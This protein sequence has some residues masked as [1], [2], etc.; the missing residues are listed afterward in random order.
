MTT[1]T[2]PQALTLAANAAEGLLDAASTLIADKNV[3]GAQQKL[4]NAET[5]LKAGYGLVKARRIDA[6]WEAPQ[7]SNPCLEDRGLRLI[8]CSAIPNVSV[9]GRQGKKMQAPYLYFDAIGV[10]GEELSTGVFEGFVT[11]EYLDPKHPLVGRLSVGFSGALSGSTSVE[12]MSNL[13]PGQQADL[14]DG[15]VLALGESSYVIAGSYT[16]TGV[17]SKPVSLTSPL[18]DTLP[19]GSTASLLCRYALTVLGDEPAFTSPLVLN[20]PTQG[21]G[22]W[23]SVQFDSVNISFNNGIVVPPQVAT[24]ESADLLVRIP[25]SANVPSAVFSLRLEGM[26]Y[27]L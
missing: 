9:G 21:S 19:S 26:V 20:Y 15:D 5:A 8:A 17:E 6:L 13:L 24:G 22:G 23:R 2:P 25:V 1:G 11:I 7:G 16:F 12:L 27:D 3:S 4:I 18:Y 14:S 10:A